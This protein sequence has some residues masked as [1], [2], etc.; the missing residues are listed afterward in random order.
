MIRTGLVA[1]L[2]SGTASV[3]GQSIDKSGQGANVQ[4]GPSAAV[5]N[6]ERITALGAANLTNEGRDVILCY[7]DISKPGLTLVASRTED[8][9]P[10][11]SRPAQEFTHYRWFYLGQDGAGA[12][13]GTNFADGV[14]ADGLLKTYN[15][16]GDEK[17]VITGLT[18]G[19]HY[20]RVRGIVNPDNIAEEELCNIQDETY[21]IY[22]LPELKVDA[23]ATVDGGAA[24]QYCE[25]AVSGTNEQAKVKVNVT[26]GFVRS[27]TPAAAG[28]DVKYR[29]YAVKQNEDGTTWPDVSVMAI[30]P[31]TI[32]GVELLVT[33]PANATGGILPDFF[34]QIDDIG[35][36]KVFVEVEYAVKD[37]NY[38]ADD[39]EGMRIRPHVIYR[40]FAQDNGND[41]ILTVTPAPGK[42]HITI[43]AIQD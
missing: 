17:L 22:V 5:D 30:E 42:P 7:N 38:S 11:P 2:L 27:N 1:L 33:S 40:G 34:P 32:S 3:F 24:F 28:F 18:E 37:R 13:N 21:V 23:V 39:A 20:F 26:Y 12:V 25:T 4:V 31:T 41:M 8:L 36:Y 9:G 16:A 19:Y 15:A 35:K 10:T 14:I 43:E 6:S 29:W